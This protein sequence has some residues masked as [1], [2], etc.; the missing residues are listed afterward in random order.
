MEI[1]ECQACHGNHKILPPSD[2]MLG[3]GKQ[4]VCSQCHEEGSAAYQ[5]ALK[6]K[7][8]ITNFKNKIELADSLLTKAYKEGVDV[9]EPQF[10][11]REA[12]NLLVMT[13]DL[14]HSLSVETV[15]EKIK[16]GDKI[17]SEVTQKGQA[18]IKEA[19]LRKTGLIIALIFVFILAFGL[20][21]KVRQINK[22][23]SI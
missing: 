14:T 9:S 6:M 5:V 20:F 17:V 8:E 12:N 11:L 3:T 13:R 7:K 22:K 16:E 23:T 1:H 15:E 21:L 10:K 19:K 4:A 2:E 18:A